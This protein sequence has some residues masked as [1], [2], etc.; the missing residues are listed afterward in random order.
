[1]HNSA[2]GQH[3]GLLF[4]LRHQHPGETSLDSFGLGL[5]WVLPMSCTARA[6]R[7]VQKGCPGCSS[8]F[9]ASTWY[10]GQNLLLGHFCH[11]REIL[12]SAVWPLKWAVCHEVKTLSLGAK[13]DV[14]NSQEAANG[15]F[16]STHIS[17]RLHCLHGKP[18]LSSSKD[19]GP[20]A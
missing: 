13:R 20:S 1:M 12:Q 6:G 11:S 17:F 7:E 19:P 3:H 18:S 9:S 2:L 10:E 14:I 15:T 4:H 5:K 8:S 16:A